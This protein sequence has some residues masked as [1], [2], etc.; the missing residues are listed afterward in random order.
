MGNALGCSR[1]EHLSLQKSSMLTS[2]TPILGNT[3]VAQAFQHVVT[4]TVKR[5]DAAGAGYQMQC[6]AAPCQALLH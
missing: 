5:E 6:V 1:L 4:L 3:H 2:L